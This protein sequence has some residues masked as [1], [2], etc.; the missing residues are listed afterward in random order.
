[1]LRIRSAQT[2]LSATLVRAART[3]RRIVEARRAPGPLA[4]S[5]RAEPW[6]RV[7]KLALE[8]LL[9]AQEEGTLVQEA[10]AQEGEE[11]LQVQR[12][13]ALALPGAMMAVWMRLR[14]Q[15][16]RAVRRFAASLAHRRAPIVRPSATAVWAAYAS[17]N[18]HSRRSV[19][20]RNSRARRA[21]V[22]K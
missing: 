10:L 21:W 9:L 1:V 6:A 15:L 20:R 4:P 17:S 8:A 3:A 7:G 16:A 5:A 14:A 18:V 11:A 12:L 13:A 22:A 19:K 2:A